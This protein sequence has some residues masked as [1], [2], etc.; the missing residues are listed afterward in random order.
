MNGDS[1]EILLHQKLRQSN[2]ALHR[3][4]KDHHLE[5]EKR[6][7]NTGHQAEALDRLYAISVHFSHLKVK[8]D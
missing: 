8:E 7:Q 5:A 3:L 4:D 1:G 2:A 6:Y